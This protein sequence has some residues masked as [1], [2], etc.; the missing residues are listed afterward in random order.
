MCHSIV[1]FLQGKN[2]PF[3]RHDRVGYGDKCVIVNASNL[4]FTGKKLLQKKVK[5]HT[6][7]TRNINVISQASLETSEKSL[8]THL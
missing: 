4:K 3:Y 6:G 1:Y 7:K 8:T 2:K 5:Y